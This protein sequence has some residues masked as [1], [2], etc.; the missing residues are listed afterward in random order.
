MKREDRY[1]ESNSTLVRQNGIERN[2]LQVPV[3][4]G[5]QEKEAW[6]CRLREGK[7]LEGH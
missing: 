4:F 7:P 2:G 6:C 5:K 1:T 3:V